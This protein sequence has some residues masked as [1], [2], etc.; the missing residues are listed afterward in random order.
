ML[1]FEDLDLIE[2]SRVAG[3]EAFTANAGDKAAPH[4]IQRFVNIYDHLASTLFDRK[5]LSSL[6]PSQ[7][8]ER[9]TVQQLT[10]AQKN[11]KD[12]VERYGYMNMSA[13]PVPSIVGLKTGILDYSIALANYT[14][15]GIRVEKTLGQAYKL[16]AELLNA[17]DALNSLSTTSR[18]TT[19]DTH[20]KYRARYNADMQKHIAEAK[21]TTEVPYGKLVRSNKEM[22]QT[23]DHRNAF[24]KTLDEKT[25]NNIETSVNK[26]AALMNNVATDIAASDADVNGRVVSALSNVL[27]EIGQMTRD[28]GTYLFRINALIGVVDGVVAECTDFTPEHVKKA[29]EEAEMAAG[30]NALA[31]YEAGLNAFNMGAVGKLLIGAIVAIIGVIAALLLRG[32]KSGDSSPKIAGA[33]NSAKEIKTILADKPKEKVKEAAMKNPEVVKE[34]V[35]VVKAG[36]TEAPPAPTVPANVPKHSPEEEAIIAKIELSSMSDAGIKLMNKLGRIWNHCHNTDSDSTAPKFD[37]LN[38]MRDPKMPYEVRSKQMDLT[39]SKCLWY[40]NDSDNARKLEEGFIV[41]AGRFSEE[42]VK[43]EAGYNKFMDAV[44][45]GD[46]IPEGSSFT[47]P[48]VLDESEQIVTAL[49]E[50]LYTLYP[51]DGPD[52]SNPEIKKRLDK[53]HRADADLVDADVIE[54][55]MDTA[56]RTR[57][58]INNEMEASQSKLNHISDV[59]RKAMHEVEK[60]VAGDAT[61]ANSYMPHIRDL[62]KAGL[63]LSSMA[64]G[65]SAYYIVTVSTETSVGLVLA[66][67]RDFGRTCQK[68]HDLLP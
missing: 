23:F 38:W 19:I 8:G 15:F 3:L 59:A 62:R 6:Y 2:Q 35:Q 39:M 65:L 13:C 45:K 14:D 20:Q 50:L 1:Y 28:Y 66:Q 41:L 18:L 32:K 68:L 67:Y 16:L 34:I 54:K 64:S 55:Y 26:I 22:L 40:V 60:R 25:K 9:F 53:Y 49:R 56:F 42:V 46:K 27:F 21:P 48:F 51:V 29:V 33:V 58:L 61:L 7:Q 24:E 63:R 43:Y 4:I 12:H 57:V 37:A 5:I 36:G 11:F 30:N 47:S 10:F 52:V 31:Q 44:R 17:D